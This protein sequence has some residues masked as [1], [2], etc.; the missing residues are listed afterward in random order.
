MLKIYK[1]TFYANNTAFHESE[2]HEEY[3]SI[4]AKDFLKSKPSKG[5][6]DQI[7]FGLDYFTKNIDV[8]INLTTFYDNKSECGDCLWITI[9]L[10]NGKHIDWMLYDGKIQLEY[11]V[12]GYGYT[13]YL[14]QTIYKGPSDDKFM[15]KKHQCTNRDQIWIYDC[16]SNRKKEH[17]KIITEEAPEFNKIFELTKKM[18]DFFKNLPI[19]SDFSPKQVHL[20]ITD[21]YISQ[22]NELIDCVVN[23]DLCKH[24]LFNSIHEIQCKIHDVKSMFDIEKLWEN[25]N[26]NKKK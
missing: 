25:P 3:N 21:T 5:I 10:P 14:Y 12:E 26:Q 9:D 24:K 4:L 13:N 11:Y 19:K 1:N 7:R 23:F 22:F 17:S 18:L 20:L 16:T 2:P 8:N 6:I 15:S